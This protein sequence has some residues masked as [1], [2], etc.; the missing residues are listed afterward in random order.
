MRQKVGRKALI[1]LL[2]VTLAGFGCNP[3]LFPMYISGMF[4]SPTQG[5]G[6]RVLQES[7]SGKEKE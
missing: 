7:Q 2:L 5:A 4:T 1:A 6:I 3:L